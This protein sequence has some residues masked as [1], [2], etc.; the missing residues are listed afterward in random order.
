M[1][2]RPRN[3]PKGYAVFVVEES[4]GKPVARERKIL[5]GNVVGNS[6]AVN[7]GLQG[8]EKEIARR[9]AGGGSAGSEGN[10]VK[11]C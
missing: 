7:A 8:G 11:E 3:D 10:S 5:L 6:I 9:N 1:R 4:N 2:S